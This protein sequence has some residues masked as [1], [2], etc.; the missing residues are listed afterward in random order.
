MLAVTNFTQIGLW[1]L[2]ISIPIIALY[3]IYLI[4]TKAFNYMGFSSI[5]AIIIVFVSF[6]FGF[7]IIVLGFN[8]S[9]IY[10]FSHGDWRIGINMGGAIIP[11]L[12]SVYLIIKKKIPLKNVLV[13]III[14]SIIAFLVTSPD[15]KKGIVSNFPYWLFPATFASFSSAFLSWK[16]FHKAAPL[17]YI[18]GTIG[19]LIGADFLHLSELLSYS[20]EKVMSAVIGGAVVFDMIFITGILAVILDGLIMFRQ[21][22]REGVH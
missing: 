2:Y 22:S 17:A 21:K 5:E 11:I 1:I 13:G 4:I 3:L 14:V 18:S 20:P 16:N 15:P 8:I 6:L 10:L 19:V 7:D 12:L 9:N